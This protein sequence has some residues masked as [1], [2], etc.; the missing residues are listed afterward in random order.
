MLVRSDDGNLSAGIAELPN[1]N[2]RQF[3]RVPEQWEQARSIATIS[4]RCAAERDCGRNGKRTSGCYHLCFHGKRSRRGR[5]GGGGC[6]NGES[7]WVATSGSDSTGGISSGGERGESVSQ[8]TI[9]EREFMH[10]AASNDARGDANGFDEL[11]L[12]TESTDGEYDRG[13]IGFAERGDLEQIQDWDGSV[14]GG[15]SRRAEYFSARGIEHNVDG[16]F[17]DVGQ[18]RDDNASTSASENG[19][20]G[21]HDKRDC[22]SDRRN[23]AAE[24]DDRNRRQ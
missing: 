10:Q 20:S 14:V 13:D 2:L 7:E 1:R 19:A 11:Y 5:N 4:A 18:G 9:A 15:P 22:E 3:F 8:W 24:R 12:W 6:D 21:M 16:E 17:V 23:Y